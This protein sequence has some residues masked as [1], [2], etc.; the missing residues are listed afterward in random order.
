MIDRA[1]R[2]RKKLLKVPIVEHTEVQVPVAAKIEDMDLCV[3]RGSGFSQLKFLELQARRH[4]DS[5][6]KARVGVDT[7]TPD[8]LKWMVDHDVRN[9]HDRLPSLK[10]PRTVKR[11][12]SMNKLLDMKLQRKWH[13]K[14]VGNVK[15]RL[16]NKL[17]S[18]TNRYRRNKSS[19]RKAG[20][21][22]GKRRGRGRGRSRERRPRTAGSRSRS[23]SRN[24]VP[25]FVERNMHMA[26]HLAGFEENQID[27]ITG[28]LN[29]YFPQEEEQ[30]AQG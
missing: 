25:D 5:V 1:Q 13:K 15:S 6:S 11:H 4:R 30:P 7:S 10:L 24:K 17:S 8:S 20:F 29:S 23:R 3:R 9:A 12:T 16:D 28:L 26:N 14:I 27:T 18:Q 22:G 2:R 21:C 19:A